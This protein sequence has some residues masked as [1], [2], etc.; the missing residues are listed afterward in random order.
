MWDEAISARMSLGRFAAR[1]RAR[2]FS[3]GFALRLWRR[4]LRS[5]TGASA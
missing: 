2:A 4:G 5:Y 1:L 3:V